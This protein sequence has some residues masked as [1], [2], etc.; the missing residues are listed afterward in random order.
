MAH[1][2]GS[3]T[4]EVLP[5]GGISPNSIC[6]DREVSV[7]QLPTATMVLPN[8]PVSGKTVVIRVLKSASIPG[9]KLVTGKLYSN[10]HMASCAAAAIWPS[11]LLRAVNPASAIWPMRLESVGEIAVP[12]PF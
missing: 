12:R 10:D 9:A 11:L 1:V 6:C 7:G 2:E 3:G 8:W 5:L 4:A